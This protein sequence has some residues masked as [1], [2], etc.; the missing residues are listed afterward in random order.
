MSALAKACEV[1]LS[2]VQAIMEHTLAAKEPMETIDVIGGQNYIENPPL[3]LLLKTL[4]NA[5]RR[6]NK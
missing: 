5:C 3:P 6:L 4:F 1:A 2:T